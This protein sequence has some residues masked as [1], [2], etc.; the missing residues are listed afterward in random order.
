MLVRDSINYSHPMLEH[1][2]NCLLR[3]INFLILIITTFSTLYE[4]Y[5]NT[6]FLYFLNNPNHQ[7]RKNFLVNTNMLVMYQLLQSI[8]IFN[9]SL[10]IYH[11][12]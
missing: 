1:E 10:S 3:T 8:S 7:K 12:R 4:I 2:N 9:K 5:L 11:A 6:I